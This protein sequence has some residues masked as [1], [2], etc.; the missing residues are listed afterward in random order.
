MFKV[1]FN[2]LHSRTPET[3][4]LRQPFYSCFHLSQIAKLQVK[5][6]VQIF[7]H[8]AAQDLKVSAKIRRENDSD[9]LIL[10]T[11][12]LYEIP[13]ANLHCTMLSPS[14]LLVELHSLQLHCSCYSFTMIFRFLMLGA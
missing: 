14:N 1:S 9:P 8:V 6:N 12:E 13:Q 4:L 3:F 10:K 7:P 2:A 5:G 11:E